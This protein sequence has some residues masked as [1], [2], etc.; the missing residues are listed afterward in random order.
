MKCKLPIFGLALVFVQ[1]QASAAGGAQAVVAGPQPAMIRGGD[2]SVAVFDDGSYALRSTAISGD[3]LHATVEVDTAAGTLTPARYPKHLASVSTFNDALGTGQLLTVTHSG[4][5]DAADL[6]C[7]FRVYADRP[8]GDIRVKVLNSTAQSVVIHSIRVI[9]SSGNAVLQL[10]GP[11]TEDRV[12]SDG[13]SEDPSQ[14]ADMGEPSGGI[15]RSFS[16][17]LIYNRKSGQS[18]FLGALSADALVTVFHLR[19]SS[20]PDAH[21][22]SYEVEDTGTTEYLHDQSQSYGVENE[23]PLRLEAAPGESASSERL[24]FAIG[25]DYHAQ[26]ENYGTAIRVLHHARTSSPTLIGWWSW[27]AYYYGVTEGT[28]QTNA[29][30]LAQNLLTTGYRYFQIDE[31]YQFARGEYATADGKAFPDG[32]A[33]TGHHVENDGL[34]F[35]LWVAPFQVSDRSWVYEHHRDW[36][37]QNLRGEPIHIGTVGGNGEELYALD[38][39]NPGAQEYLR[40]TYRT[41]VNGWGARFLKMD[42]ME[43]AAVEGAHYRPNTTGLEAL[44]IGLE[45]IRQTVGD[46]VILDKDGSPMLT[47]VG[48]VDTGRISQDTGHTFGSTHDAAPGIAGRY[49]MN[50]NFYESDPDAFT[51]SEQITPDRG[52]HGNKVPLTLDEAEASIALSAVSGGMFE[53]GD[54]LPALGA[55][56]QRMALVRNSDLLDMARL[57]RASIPLDLM[58]YREEDKQP[59]IFLLKEDNRQWILT[60]FNWTEEP[61]S[62]SITFEDLGIKPEGSFTASDVLRGGMLPITGGRMAIDQPAHSVRMLKLVKNSVTAQSPDFEM[63]V[64]P[65]AQG[66]ETVEFR[67]ISSGETPVLGYRWNFGDGVTGDGAEVRHTYTQPGSYTVTVEAMGLDKRSS[68]KT[69]TIAIT[70]YVPTIYDAARKERYEGER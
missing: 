39:T 64:P 20:R 14:I 1:L 2:L 30:W 62:H 56:P 49:Y 67:A 36:L 58:T 38:T 7:E 33:A 15:H 5:Q 29:D 17:Q 35:G 8:W 19:S 50:H 34:T 60:V 27:T 45:V 26:L 46:D 40:Q 32:M 44:R 16:S 47:P 28:M 55:S 25:P 66:G 65:S 51:V 70:G 18:L 52:W 61:R 37:V 53:I 9:K 13:L 43:S 4:L 31:G 23:V 21:V 3:V 69:M 41:L 11:G 54:D 42:F 12:L 63:R 68:T 22:S 6:V 48:I 24:M 57:G 59:S 10:N